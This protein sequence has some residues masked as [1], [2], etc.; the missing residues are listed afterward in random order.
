MRTCLIVMKDEEKLI[1]RKEKKE[2]KTVKKI[3]NIFTY[4]IEHYLHFTT[5]KHCTLKK[6][7][8]YYQKLMV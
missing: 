6:E 8:S 7:F 5:L 1:F 3:F 4:L 2:K